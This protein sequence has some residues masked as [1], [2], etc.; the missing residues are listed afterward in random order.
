MLRWLSML[1][2]RRRVYVC[3]STPGR[4]KGCL[5]HEE[6]VRLYTKDGLST[7]QIA[8]KDGT[9]RL[10]ILGLLRREGVKLRPPGSGKNRW[11]TH[12]LC[13]G[14]QLSGVAPVTL[15]R[16]RLILRLGGKCRLCRCSDLRVL[17]INHLRDKRRKLKLG[18]LARLARGEAPEL[19]V[20]CANCNILYEYE[21]GR[22][23]LP[24]PQSLKEGV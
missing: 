9:T 14:Y 21:M 10:T 18:D 13:V 2:S 20:R 4:M 3:S 15:A 17:E 19:E 16:F 7:V 1:A 24:T 11:K 22:R 6:V 8:R 12:G 23:K 5:S